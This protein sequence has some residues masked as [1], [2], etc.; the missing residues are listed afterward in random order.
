MT[1]QERTMEV[2]TT[3]DLKADLQGKYE[4]FHAPVHERSMPSDFTRIASQN[5]AGEQLR[6][7]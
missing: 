2:M 1:R 4:A 7:V 3:T 6:L 5:E